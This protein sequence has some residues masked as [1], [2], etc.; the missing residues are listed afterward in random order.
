MSNAYAVP[1][2]PGT[3]ACRYCGG[4]N[5]RAWYPVD[6]GQGI[7]VTRLDDGALDFEYDGVTE[8]GESGA[9]DEYWC[10][11]CQG[12]AKTLE[13]LVGD[14]E[15]DGPDEPATFALAIPYNLKA[16]ELGIEPDTNDAQYHEELGWLIANAA[17]D[18][19][20]RI[21]RAAVILFNAKADADGSSPTLGDCLYTAIVYERG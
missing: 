12:S 2:K 19:T 7:D 6:E 5:F 18:E 16:V 20:E 10:L 13:Y 3:V 14:T 15:T 21:L 9:N 4:S 8:S 1:P 11:D 17:E